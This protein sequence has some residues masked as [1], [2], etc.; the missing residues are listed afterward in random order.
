MRADFAFVR[1]KAFRTQELDALRFRDR[2]NV[3]VIYL[4]VFDFVAQKLRLKVRELHAARLMR[5]AISPRFGSRT[6]LVLW[7]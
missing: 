5:L 7:V 2:V 6:A 3:W 1:F 4:T